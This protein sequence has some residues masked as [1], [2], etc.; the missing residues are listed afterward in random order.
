MFFSYLPNCVGGRGERYN[1]GTSEQIKI[2]DSRFL[3]LI[4]RHGPEKV[5]IFTPKDRTSD[6]LRPGSKFQILQPFPTIKWGTYSVG[7]RCASAFFL[8]RPR[9]TDV[10]RLRPVVKYILDLPKVSFA[11]IQP[12]VLGGS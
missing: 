9:P 6:F 10:D 8:R 5:L 3:R 7:D 1:S 12:L 4:E 2:A 11:P